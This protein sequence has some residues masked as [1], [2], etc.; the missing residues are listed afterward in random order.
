[1][2]HKK[3]LKA[4]KAARKA[5]SEKAEEDAG[6]LLTLFSSLLPA[7][8]EK[9]PAEEVTEVQQEQEQASGFQQAARKGG[10]PV[11]PAGKYKF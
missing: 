6:M 8:R 7:Q 11:I 10:A 5:A 3:T 4:C 1:M 9:M 2:R